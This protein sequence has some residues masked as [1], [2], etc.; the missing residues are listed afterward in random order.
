MSQ[1][2]TSITTHVLSALLFVALFWGAI[3]FFL[4]EFP[5]LQ[6]ER[7]PAPNTNYDRTPVQT[8]LHHDAVKKELLS[9]MDFGSRS[10]GQPGHQA[11]ADHIEKTYVDS[12]LQVFKQLIRTPH[13]VNERCEILD[14]QGQPLPIATYPLSPSHVQPA[15]TPDAGISGRLIIADAEVMDQLTSF[16]DCFIVIN[17]SAPQPKNYSNSVTYYAA[18]GAIGV[19]FTH[20]EG[21]NE[22]KWS[23]SMDIPMP[24]NFPVLYADKGILDY[25]N[26]SV[27]IH[28]LTRIKNIVSHNIVGVLKTTEAAQDAIIIPVSYDGYTNLPDLNHGTFNALQLAIQ[29]Q[30]LKG[31]SK[32]D[33]SLMK[34]DIIFAATSNDFMGSYSQSELIKTV[35]LFKDSLNSEKKIIVERD[36]NN[37]RLE[38]VR[39]ILKLFQ[40]D[41]FAI[42]PD[43]TPGSISKL[44]LKTNT[45]LEEQVTY[46]LKSIVLL[47]SEDL[48]QAKI[49]FEKTNTSDLETAEFKTY[50]DKKR[51]YDKANSRSAYSFKKYVIV[52]SG[53]DEFRHQLE[54]R[55][56]H[57]LAYHDE[58]D[59][60]IS[61]DLKLNHLFAS[62]KNLVVVSPA[63]L[64]VIPLKKKGGVKLNK[65]DK[66]LKEGLTFTMGHKTEHGVE[67]T[68]FKDLLDE[69][70]A[71]LQL[72]DDVTTVFKG[73]KHAAYASGVVSAIPVHSN[74]W[75]RISIPAFT[76]ASLNTSY[77]IIRY[78]QPAQDI[79]TY[80]N[81]LK[82]SMTI[83][84]GTILSIVHG[85]KVFNKLRKFQVYD[86]NGNVYTS[87]G[88]SIVPNFPMEGAIITLNNIS[89]HG[90]FNV[91]SGSYYA[92][93]LM[94]DPYGRY[95][96]TLCA[97]ALH[98]RWEHSPEAA[99]IGANGIIQYYKDIGKG[100]TIYKSVKLT[101]KSE[102]VH[103]VL[104]RADAVTILDRTNPQTLKDYSNA[105]FLRKSGLKEF[106]SYNEFIFPQ[107]ILKFL[108]PDERFFVTLK[109][110]STENELVQ[111]TRAFM[112][113]ITDDFVPDP[114]KEI[115]GAG[116]LVADTPILL[117]IPDE[118]AKSMA[119]LNRKRVNIQKEYDMVDEMTQAFY[120]TSQ[121]RL[122]TENE[123]TETYIKKMRRYAQSVIYSILIH[124]IIRTNITEAVWGILWYMS[125]LVPFVFFFE[126]L[127][128]GYT[129][130]RKQLTVQ[131]GIFLIVFIL[132]RF[133]HPAFQMI[134]SSAMILL[135]FIIILISMGITIILSSKFREN[136]D[137][138]MK[139]QG[140]VKGAKV[141][142]MGVVIT[143]FMLG[144]NN[145]HRR[146][147]RTGLTCATLVLLTF[148]MI[149]FTSV[150]SD[151]VDTTTAVSKSD[152]DGFLVKDD[153]YIAISIGE[154]NA[155]KNRYGR[156]YEISLRSHY[157]GY[158]EFW[159]TKALHPPIIELEYG[160]DDDLKSCSLLSGILLDATE[161]L[162]HKIKFISSTPWF[163]TPSELKDEL[164]PIM[165]SE[166]KANALGLDIADVNAGTA[167][168]KMKNKQCKVLGVF[169]AGSLDALRDIDGDGLL[170]FDI[171]S[172]LQ[173]RNIAT[174]VLGDREMPKVPASEVF[175]SL[176]GKF[177]IP[178]FTE[179]NRAV[180]KRVVS[181]VINLGN[182][183]FKT[184]KIEID[185]FLEQSGRATYFSLNNI[186]Y[187]GKRLRESSMSGYV[188]MLIPLLIAALT[189]LNTMK[190]S[191]Y[192]RQDE[193]YVYNAV[194]IAPKY[195]FFMFIAEAFVYSVIGAMLGYILS[196]GTGRILTALDMTGG[197]NMNFTS[198]STVY[199]SLTIIAAVF[200]STAYPALQ[201]MRI[202][203]PAEDSGWMLPEPQQD[204]L[205]FDLPFT[206]DHH[207]RIAV[208]AFFHKYLENHGEGSAGPFFAGKPI[209]G[210]SDTLDELNNQAY[211]PKVSVPIWLKPF[212][213]GVSQRMDIELATDKDTGEYVSRVILTRESGAKDAWERLNN[214]FVALIRKHFLHWRAVPD[215]MKVELY[216]TAKQQL[217]TD[218]AL[219]GDKADG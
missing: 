4:N 141:N 39:A 149:C 119:F 13:P 30:L 95:K 114:E 98:H 86:I 110:G 179:L 158:Y 198:L 3:V 170:P 28:M 85:N 126:K 139:S 206:F 82:N 91:T 155:L 167:V 132:L 72:S 16:S 193:L 148:V 93:M 81:R 44:T 42:N 66:P 163:L 19:I 109:S 219:A 168:I 100:Q 11:C 68:T 161:P 64:P 192:E 49:K 159:G 67:A 164:I 154:I 60:R 150:Q 23:L 29:L 175:I 1:K 122:T 144:L 160:V 116:Y 188:D 96:Q 145:M 187:F 18:L 88:T 214:G 118:V 171:Q 105:V 210:I 184:K 195:I 197:L 147:V 146:K 217:A 103:I 101:G 7:P 181:A 97:T 191:V 74:M 162:R 71:E 58:E 8:A 129:D 37:S 40:D 111:E 142:T 166:E 99:Y 121:A 212:D 123:D 21:V 215:E 17:L 15:V 130:I 200:V 5:P 205:S 127:V 20:E 199:A 208:L 6:F 22:V 65:T 207:D 9:I 94:T 89:S 55:F 35:G 177:N 115:D 117:N 194:G 151:I 156:D 61:Q 57:L 31:L 131:A 76:V 45:F 34:R 87:I 51:Q 189:V 107:G 153:D 59:V 178:F 186:S 92:N 46:I 43:S 143:A 52:H 90:I 211:I 2:Q 36:D 134:R 133:L 78:S 176:N 140:H 24:M 213:L 172:I 38:H 27:T 203:S 84:G 26:T 62:Y 83:F 106:E 108:R 112:L 25:N 138:L 135:G 53:S 70:I 174:K 102:N 63:L 104:F 157:I 202:A 182:T 56:T 50:I 69:S 190:G 41:R 73:N 32:T 185:N 113:G 54:S 173:V 10:V 180:P 12:G 125:L 47:K 124:P 209:L 77:T 152:F 216:E 33:K 183:D 137:A 169:D 136:M 128:F 201:A 204:T 48:L 79:P 80:L 196:Q 75:S 120:E 218:I 165:I 14:K